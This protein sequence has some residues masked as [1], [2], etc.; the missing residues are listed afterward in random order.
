MKDAGNL[1]LRALLALTMA[2]ES[3]ADD[4]VPSAV[5]VCR[6]VVGSLRF[7]DALHRHPSSLLLSDTALVFTSWRT[8]VERKSHRTAHAVCNVCVACVPFL[9]TCCKL[10]TSSLPASCRI[11]NE[12]DLA[13]GTMVSET[14]VTGDRFVAS[15]SHI[16]VQHHA[17]LEKSEGPRREAQEQPCPPSSW[18]RSLGCYDAKEL[19]VSH[20][21]QRNTFETAR[22]PLRVRHCSVQPRRSRRRMRTRRRLS[23]ENAGKLRRANAR[24]PY[25][26][27]Q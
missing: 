15:T 11:L 17:P 9:T 26:R 1:D 22:Q 23:T 5:F 25:E 12:L 2:V 20:P 6:L 3:V 16:W 8:T 7:D 14:P 21:C 18:R 13:A 4:Q 10:C 19:E 27:R 24:H